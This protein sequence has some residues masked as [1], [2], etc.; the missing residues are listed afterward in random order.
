MRYP[1][2]SRD[3]VATTMTRGARHAAQ[4]PGSLW[5]CALN[6]LAWA[7]RRT[8][9]LWITAILL[10]CC[11]IVAERT[12]PLST[13][14]P[15]RWLRA[16][17]GLM[18]AALALSSLVALC[19]LLTT[20]LERAAQRERLA[21]YVLRRAHSLDVRDY[22][23][24]YVPGVYI[25][26]RDADGG[27]AA[28]TLAWTALR[29]AA[30][31][32]S[33]L[34]ADSPLGICVF[35]RPGDG[36]TRLAWEALQAEL[37]RW[38]VMRWPHRPLP[39]LDPRI[40]RRRRVVLWL[41]DAHEF[42][43]PNDAVLL[44]DL[45][46]RCA[47]AGVRLVIIATCRDGADE[48]RACRQL[49]SV[50]ERLTAIRPSR[51][52][53]DEADMLASALDK[54]GSR[55]RRRDFTGTPASM[56]LG[57][58]TARNEVYPAL[59]EEARRVLAAIKL[60][61]SAGVAVYPIPT[62]RATA[63]DVFDLAPSSWSQALAALLRSGF[64]QLGG[65]DARHNILLAPVSKVMLDTAVP[66]YLT[67]NGEPSE[68]WPWLQDALERQHNAEGLLCLGNSLSELRTGGGPFLPYDPRVSKQLAVT[69]FR[70][71]LE[72]TPRNRSAYDW[73]VTQA[74]LGLALYRQADLA[75]A[76][77]RADLQRQSSAAY[78]AALEIITRETL[79]A[80]WAMIQLSLTAVYKARA[81]DSVYAGDVEGACSALRDAWRYVENALTVYSL[82]ADPSHYR[83]SLQAREGILDAMREL[84]CTPGD[85]EDVDA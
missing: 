41:D 12:A 75:T 66:D 7:W 15:V 30:R 79:P 61:R 77:L 44:N 35:G 59:P 65:I 26:R 6:G 46:R 18:G 20:Q 34:K 82:D 31:R 60:L 25:P 43:T 36:K 67:R 4:R 9:W 40:L 11:A 27:G 38:T 74:N 23:P 47:R 33:L 21:P 32:K 17:P 19:G 54:L 29:A 51:L 52:S 1:T 62:V 45:P 57:L 50:M 84:D 64:L 13:W 42:A 70:A 85:G 76:Y 53:V 3:A 37:P 28:D 69:C 49:G 10:V 48:T 58:R 63:V 8:R 73:A 72:Y 78:R 83:L 5:L 81:K 55:V 71:A 80:E 22:V 39:A 56:V 2:T 24:G 16:Q 14:E 68:D